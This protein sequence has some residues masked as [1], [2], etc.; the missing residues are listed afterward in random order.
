MCLFGKHK[1]QTN[2]HGNGVGWK[3]ETITFLRE[4]DYPLWHYINA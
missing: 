1:N 4:K 2:K 3:K